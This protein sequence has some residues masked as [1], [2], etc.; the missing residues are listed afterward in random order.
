MEEAKKT[1]TSALSPLCS[2]PTLTLQSLLHILGISLQE[3]AAG[4]WFAAKVEPLL[5]NFQTVHLGFCNA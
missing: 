4:F 5:A 2:P 1:Q 3:I